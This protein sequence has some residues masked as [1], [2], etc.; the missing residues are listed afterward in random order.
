MDA[1]NM[2]TTPNHAITTI[3]RRKGISG[4]NSVEMMS[5]T[6]FEPS[7]ISSIAILILCEKERKNVFVESIGYAT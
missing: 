4:K 1:R 3:S 6:A 5:P 2:A 7:S